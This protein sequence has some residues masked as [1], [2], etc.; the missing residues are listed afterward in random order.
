MLTDF[1]GDRERSHAALATLGH[2]RH[3]H[4][5]ARRE[6]RATDEAAAADATTTNDDATAIDM[7]NNDVRLRALK[8]VAETLAPIDQKKAVLYFSAGH[9]KERRRQSGRTA[10][11][12][13]RGGARQRLDLSG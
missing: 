10:G 12:D 3:R 5:A 7:F 11:G 9:P 4:A 13:Q 6:H 8:A 2:R 1:T